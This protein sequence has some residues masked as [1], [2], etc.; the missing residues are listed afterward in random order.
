[1]KR[2]PQTASFSSLESLLKNKKTQYTELGKRQNWESWGQ[3]QG[4]A[5]PLGVC[6]AGWVWHYQLKRA[7]FQLDHGKA[8]LQ[9]P[10]FQMLGI[11]YA[12]YY[13]ILY[14]WKHDEWLNSVEEDQA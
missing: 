3:S 14:R 6:G 5:S 1:M 12:S 9:G 2:Q 13:C 7:W 11:S 8:I 4:L 10:W